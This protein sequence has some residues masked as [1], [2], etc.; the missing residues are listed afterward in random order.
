MSVGPPRWT[1][2]FAVV[3]VVITLASPIRALNAQDSNALAQGRDLFLA[4]CSNCHG[5]D[6]TGSTAHQI[7]L[8][9]EPP[10]F[11]ESS[12]ASREPKGDWAGVVFEG[13]PLRG[14]DRMMPSFG[15]ALTREEID[16]ILDYMET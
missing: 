2:L 6:G 15:G 5:A 1:V 13:G 14:F 10:D 9:V 11:T 3:G 7:G 8:P 16:L 4:A 12:F